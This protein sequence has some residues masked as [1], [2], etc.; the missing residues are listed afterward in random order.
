M[1]KKA[2]LYNKTDETM[3]VKNY[4]A[5]WGKEVPG[6][7]SNLEWYELH[8]ET[9]P[10]YNPAQYDLIEIYTLTEETGEF[11][12]IVDVEYE[13]VEKSESEIINYL[14]SSVG[15]Y[16]DTNYPWWEQNKHQ[17]RSLRFSQKLHSNIELTADEQAYLSYI[18]A[19][20]DWAADC[21]Q[22]RDDYEEIYRTEGELPEI[23]W[24]SRP[25]K[26]DYYS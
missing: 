25:V 13:L 6:L 7:D 8:Y 18:I 19:C 21:R 14:N 12:K 3:T 11:L 9:A 22:L 10:P 20:A 2:L 4:A 1:I 23:A 16:I 24:P 15:E 26:E 5:L 17:G